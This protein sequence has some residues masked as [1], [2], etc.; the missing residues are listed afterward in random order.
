MDCDTDDQL[1]CLLIPERFEAMAIIL[2]NFIQYFLQAKLDSRLASPCYSTISLTGVQLSVEIG[3]KEIH[4][5][6]Q[7]EAP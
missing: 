7:Q 1:G 3:A 5:H 2:L 4:G 6:P